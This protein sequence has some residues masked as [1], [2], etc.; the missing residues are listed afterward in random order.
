MERAALLFVAQAWLVPSLYEAYVLANST[1]RAELFTDR[2]AIT[3][4]VVMTL[5]ALAAV[6]VSII[7]WRA[8]GLLSAR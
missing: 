3:L 2:Q 6:G 8:T 4:G 1:T 5:L 7:Y